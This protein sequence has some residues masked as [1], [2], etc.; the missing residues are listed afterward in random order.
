MISGEAGGGQWWAGVR[1]WVP[2]ALA[3]SRAA[4]SVAMVAGSTAA[5]PGAASVGAAWPGA[6][7][8]AV[9]TAGLASD[10]YDG[11][12]AR[13]WGVATAAL[14]RLDSAVDVGF[15]AAGLAAGW[16]LHPAAVGRWG[17]AIAGLLALE[18]AVQA[19]SLV[20]WRAVQ[21]TH[22]WAA[23]A[24]GLALWAAFV[25]LLGFGWAGAIPVALAVGYAADVEV[26]AILILAPTPPVDVRS[27]MAAW[28][29]RRVAARP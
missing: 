23:K 9:L 15:Y 4:M 24:W 27:A 18:A 28:R 1:A 22:S 14:R 7:W 21:A 6:A 12:L 2:M 11:V 26:L 19:T 29:L 3:L 25:A 5:W 20:R 16:R 13:R 8:V 17:W 10:V